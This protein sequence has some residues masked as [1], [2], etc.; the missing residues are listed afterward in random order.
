M[1]SEHHV[2]LARENNFLVE[3]W[4]SCVFPHDLMRR[5]IPKH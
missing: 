4:V 1:S 3:I 2:V 5:L